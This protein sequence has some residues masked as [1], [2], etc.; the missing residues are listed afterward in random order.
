MRSATPPRPSD[1]I[2]CGNALQQLPSSPF[3]MSCL[4]RRPHLQLLGQLADFGFWVAAVPTKGLQE[5]QP[6]FLG[7]AGH[8]LGRHVQDVG[9]L[10]GMKVAGRVGDGLAAALGYHRASPFRAADPDAVPGPDGPSGRPATKEEGEASDDAA[11]TLLHAVRTGRSW[12]PTPSAGHSPIGSFLRACYL[13]HDEAAKRPAPPEH[14]EAWATAR[15][16][17]SRR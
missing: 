14:G 8:G 10:G 12:G 11:I 7:P 6:A 15:R 17:R 9:H 16:P 5:R 1:W 2:P 4:V 13:A 3:Q